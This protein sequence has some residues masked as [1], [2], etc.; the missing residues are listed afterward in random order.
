MPFCVNRISVMYVG[1]GLP[2][3]VLLLGLTY[4]TGWPPR[5]ARGTAL[6][7]VASRLVLQGARGCQ[8]RPE[9]AVEPA[10]GR[11]WAGSVVPTIWIPRS[12]SSLPTARSETAE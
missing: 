11:S 6:G 5:L 8:R 1:I 7:P 3:C 10:W 12:P 4:F 2:P 9:V